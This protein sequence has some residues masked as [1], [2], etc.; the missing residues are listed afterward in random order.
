VSTP[1]E[2]PGLDDALARARAAAKDTRSVVL[3][4]R[5]NGAVRSPRRTAP[6]QG[7][8]PLDDRGQ[9]QRGPQRL[10]ERRQSL[11]HP[12]LVSVVLYRSGEHPLGSRCKSGS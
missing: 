2:Q 6:A 7:P 10:V 5:V 3:G 12:L 11:G 1:E 4:H 8:S 9:F